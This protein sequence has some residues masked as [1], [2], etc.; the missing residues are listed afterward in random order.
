M[1]VRNAWYA[2]L[3]SQ[4]LPAGQMVTRTL[5]D[6]PVVFVRNDAGRAAALLDRCPHRFVP[7]SLGARVPGDRIRCVY[8][9]LEFGLDGAC[10]HNP[11]GSGRIPPAARTRAYPV[12]ERHGMVWIWMGDAP[13][14][15]EAIPDFGFLEG[16]PDCLLSARDRIV[17]RA[18]ADLIVEN[19]LDLSHAS[20]L[21]DGILGSAATVAAQTEVEQH[22][23][24]LTVRRWMPGVP[25]PRLFDTFSEQP[26]RRVDMWFDMNW[27][28]PC[29]LV[30]DVGATDPGSDR[31]LG[32]R[33]LGA[34]ILTPET[35]TTTHY[36]FAAALRVPPGHDAAQD[37]RIG[38]TLSE[39]RRYAF[40]Q[41][42]APVIEAQQRELLRAGPDAPRPALFEID[43][44]PVRYRR[45]MDEMLAREARA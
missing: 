28:A 22:A 31:S 44:G 27:Q 12:E 19:L 4:E 5:L 42:D 38:R 39:I 17:I 20:F 11:H 1:Y 35:A 9:G 40:E 13:A 25:S 32:Y 36:H 26:G 21:H 29:A 3:W 37:A 34:H 43:V 15:P 24:G 7:L 8:H 33:I 6:E 45:M 14:A 41:Q 23:R 2:A 16:G 30:N 10:A 18:G